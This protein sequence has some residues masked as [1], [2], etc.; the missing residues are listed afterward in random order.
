M[1]EEEYNYFKTHKKELLENYRNKF[2]VI[3][4]KELIGAYDTEKEAYDS[5]VNTHAVGTFLIQKCVEN[6][7]ELIQSFHSRV[8]F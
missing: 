5:T 1:L 7:E 2:V 8:I 4:N 3:K 6:E